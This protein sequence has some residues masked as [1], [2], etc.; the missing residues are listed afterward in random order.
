[1]ASLLNIVNNNN[2]SA[3]D[4]PG[5]PGSPNYAG[6]LDYPTDLYKKYPGDYRYVWEPNSLGYNVVNDKLVTPTNIVVDEIMSKVN[7]NAIPFLSSADKCNIPSYFV[8]DVDRV[9]FCTEQLSYGLFKTALV[10]NTLFS[11]FFYKKV[12]YN[13]LII[14]VIFHVLLYYFIT[15]LFV[16]ISIGEWNTYQSYKHA[17]K[18]DPDYSRFDTPVIQ[19]TTITDFLLDQPINKQKIMYLILIV[20]FVF[21]WVPL[22]FNLISP[23]N[24]RIDINKLK[25]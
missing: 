14:F 25:R 4:N 15:K 24:I 1:M 22:K 8:E 11:I 12:N 19:F 13:F 17:V 5:Y 9:K 6:N 23:E 7:Y 18:N 3:V 2:A 21:V 16:N 20:S 10:I